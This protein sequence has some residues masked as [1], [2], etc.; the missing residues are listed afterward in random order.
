MKTELLA[1]AGSFECFKQALYNGADA[2]YLATER[3]GARAYAKNLTLDELK[4]ALIL[5]HELNKKIYV[6]A[7]TII[8]ENELED[9]KNYLNTLYELGVDGVI[10][11]DFA[12]VNHIIN[13]L[14]EMECHISTQ[15]GL[16]D[17]NDVRFF[18]RLGAKRCVL[19]RE[20]TYEEI[21]YIKENSTM[22]LEIFGYGA[23]CVSYSGGCLF[24][25]LLSLRSGNRGRCSQ[26]CRRL[27]QIYK[28]DKLFQDFGYHLSMKDL[29]TSSNLNK[30]Q[31]IGIDS[32]K[33]EGRMKSED[34]VKTVTSE[35]RKKLDNDSYNPILDNV[36][37][38]TYTK[39]FIFGED[40]GYIV[41]PSKR[42][43]EGAY[44]GKI[45]GYENN[46]TK[47]KLERKLSLKDRVRIEDK[48]DYYFTIDKILNEKKKEESS[49][50]SICYL[51]I[52][53]KKP[54][55][56]KIYKVM[57]ANIDLSIDNKFKKPIIIKAYGKISSPLTLRATIDNHTFEAKSD[58][59]IQES[60]NRP[61]TKD[62]LFKQLNK[63]AETS[64][65]L[66]DIEF[67][68]ASD[69]FMV[70]KDI[71]EVRR[72]LI[73]SIEDF[74]Q[75]KRILNLS[76]DNNTLSFD[77][78]DIELVCK[79]R[80]KEQYDTLKELGIKTIYYNNYIP[81]VDAKYNDIN[82]DYILA[83]NYGAIYNYQN[84]TITADYSFNAINSEA[85]YNLLK[86]GARYVTLSL[87]TDYDL[88]KEITSSFKNKYGFNAPL[89]IV[90]YGRENLM[91]MKYCPLRKYKECGK[92]HEHSYYLK[93][94]Y[95]K[96]LLYSD[97]CITHIINEKPLN[98]V[99]DLD[100]ITKLIK[101]IRLDFT[102]EGKDEVIKTITQFRNSL[103]GKK[104]QFDKELNT[105]GYFKRPIL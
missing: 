8:K 95:S 58:S 74:Y 62:D 98:L 39:G 105:R 5:A 87:E 67:N 82:E 64:F 19:A 66:D 85:I 26:N 102:V 2:I 17:L 15:S 93:D 103:N 49:S 46:L 83:G 16:K 30:L 79:C 13:N 63:L 37:H 99:D 60:K 76:E 91:T 35:L 21:K 9:A 50:S 73:S 96:F 104:N 57:D 28:D 34:Y 97:N 40:K 11:T 18:E 14:P 81:Y 36:F 6:T 29:N 94:E 20:N 52:F 84:K 88:M 55:G 33:I 59:L 100:K 12:L 22:P 48:E 32:L 65:Y 71:N 24:S 54:I 4:K 47:I 75:N 86:Q 42:T 25:S 68:L 41:D 92:C 10:T 56:S 80:T 61:L 44:I 70:I 31:S 43:N 90:C 23:L 27:Y 45:I 89:E 53:N 38:R 72:K 3:F 69:C 77:D 1:P 7:N 101:R 78:S 51:N